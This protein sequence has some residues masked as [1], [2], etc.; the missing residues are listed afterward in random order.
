LV[1]RAP[2]IRPR[3]GFWHILDVAFRCA[4]PA[5]LTGIVLIV[6]GA[7][8]GIPGQAQLQ[9]AWTLACVFFWSLYRPAAMPAFIVFLLGLLLDLSAEAPL[10]VS[11]LIL[12]LAH[13]LALRSRRVLVRQGF[14]LVWLVFLGVAAGAAVTE[15]VL[16][17]LLTW[18]LLP[19]WPALFEFLVTAGFYPAL[20]TLLIRAHRGPAAP[21][22]AA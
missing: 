5:V 2:G 4:L 11:A 13:G 20:A 6:L 3:P 21:E 9:P 14:A 16:V 18:R 19:P 15:W 10:G 7:P 1:D 8:F 17:S 22:R 12:M